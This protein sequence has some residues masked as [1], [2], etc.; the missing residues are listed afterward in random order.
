MIKSQKHKKLLLPVHLNQHT[1]FRR[2]RRPRHS[3]GHL[4]RSWALE[5]V[6]IRLAFHM[7]KY[8]I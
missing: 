4:A 8:P 1:V 2:W 7:K 6:H 3:Q 5:T